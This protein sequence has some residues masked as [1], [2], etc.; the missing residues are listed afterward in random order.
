MSF[1]SNLSKNSNDRDYKQ[2]CSC[3]EYN[4]DARLL[5]VGCGDGT[6]TLQFARSIGITNKNIVGIDIR[7]RGLPF[8]LAAGDINNGLPFEDR[9]FDVITASQV[10]EHLSNTDAFVKEIRRSLKVGG[11]VAIMTPNLASG[12][13]IL[14]LLLDRQPGDMDISDYFRIRRTRDP[15]LYGS[16]HRR[17]FTMEGLSKLLVYYGFKI[18]D[19][20]RT[21]YGF[22]LPGKF[23]RGR[24]ATNLIVKA[25]KL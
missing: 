17:L 15:D 20:K 5:D 8:Q 13:I 21:G 14:D 2:F 18:E 1:K 7:D 24:Y 10:I 12:Q 3:L 23:L 25:R 4:P 19:K 16:L 6:R 9:T 11:Y 22:F